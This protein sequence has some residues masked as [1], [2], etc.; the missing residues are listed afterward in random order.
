MR[1]ASLICG[2]HRAFA[3][4]LARTWFVGTGE[5]GGLPY[6]SPSLALSGYK[7]GF[8]DVRG[9]KKGLGFREK[10]QARALAF[11]EIFIDLDAF[12]QSN[13]ASGAGGQHKK[14]PYVTDSETLS[15]QVRLSR[16]AREP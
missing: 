2:R 6:K 10:K 5:R 4:L 8:E 11:V 14:R 7:G 16:R 12:V 1:G 15:V 3:S 9:F 13:V